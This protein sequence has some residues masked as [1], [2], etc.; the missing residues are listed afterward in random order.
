MLN[1]IKYIKYFINTFELC[2]VTYNVISDI[3]L[4]YYVYNKYKGIGRILQ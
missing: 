1:Y 3:Y 4:L 2:G